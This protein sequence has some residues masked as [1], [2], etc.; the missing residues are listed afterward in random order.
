VG[1]ADP[2]LLLAH[3]DVRYLGDLS[4][5]Q[6]SQPREAVHAFGLNIALCEAL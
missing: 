5:G 6:V 3:A 2:L 4:G 1:H